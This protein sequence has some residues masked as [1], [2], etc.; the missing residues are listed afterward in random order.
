MEVGAWSRVKRAARHLM[1]QYVVK[2]ALTRRMVQQFAHKYG[3]VYFGYVDNK[4]DEHELER[5]HT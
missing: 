5:G 1:P 4:S 3:L 2:S